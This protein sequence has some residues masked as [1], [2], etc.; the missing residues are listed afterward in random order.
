MWNFFFSNL[1]S[2]FYFVF[3]SLISF[4]VCFIVSV[5]FINFFYCLAFYAFFLW[6]LVLNNSLN[7]SK[8]SCFA[9]LMNK[10]I[11]TQDLL[12]F[13]ILPSFFFS[14]ICHIFGVWPIL[15]SSRC[16]IILHPPIK[17]SWHC[18]YLIKKRTKSFRQNKCENG[19]QYKEKLA[20]QLS[21]WRSWNIQK[22]LDPS[23]ILYIPLFFM[24]RVYR[25]NELW[26]V[27]S[28]VSSINP[29]LNYLV[30][31]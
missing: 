4:V 12:C 20:E 13:V 9:K 26:G 29:L 23:Y 2:L 28:P 8:V 19:C 1:F 15:T 11:L 31:I 16:F 30:T 22:Q 24:L 3:C 14:I 18:Y 6:F 5:F 21:L 7:Y 25:L 10:V 27:V 17:G